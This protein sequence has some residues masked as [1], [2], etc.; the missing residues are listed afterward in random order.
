MSTPLV[1]IR[2]LSLSYGATRALSDVSLTIDHGEVFA[3]VGPS[4]CGKTSLLRCIAG[5]EHPSAGAIEIDGDVVVSSGV[6]VRPEKRRQCEEN[7]YHLRSD[8]SS[9]ISIRRLH[10]NGPAS[11]C[12]LPEGHF[13]TIRSI[14]SASPMP[15]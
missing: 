15:K 12:T 8:Y 2:D 1:Q 13:T 5:F 3:L 6:W 11:S 7:Q 4:G 9:I 10:S 14:F